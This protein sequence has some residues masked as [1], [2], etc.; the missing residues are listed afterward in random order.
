MKILFIG[1]IVGS[2]GRN[3]FRKA[4]PGI[5]QEFEVDFVIANAEN[6]AGGS[7]ITEK[8]AEDLFSAGADA[9]TSGDHI[10][11]KSE[12]V[13][14]IDRERRILRPANAAVQAPGRGAEVFELPGGRRV[15]VLN[16]QG[17]V[18]MEPS[19][20]PFKAA[21]DALQDI[22]SRAKIIIVDMHA[23]ATSEKVAMGWFLDGKVSAVLGTHTHVQTA[24]ERILPRGTAYITDV[25]MCG[26]HDSVIG[27]KIEHVLH[28]FVT[29]M[30]VRF[31]VA[32]DNV[33]VQGV[34]VEIDEESGRAAAITRV[35]AAA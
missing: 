30:P 25:G 19:E 24:D 27:R 6:S 35:N 23:E 17:R 18:F 4:L 5:K 33:R 28:R 34:V 12:I 10:W 26:P 2:P 9:L 21:Q 11:K 14:L 32:E 29:G 16:L 1:D 7:G 22:S 13:P 8:T 3:G 31:E 15:G 20:C